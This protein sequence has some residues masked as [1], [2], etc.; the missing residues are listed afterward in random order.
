MNLKYLSKN[1]LEE[2][3]LLNKKTKLESSKE[4]NEDINP[5]LLNLEQKYKDENLIPNKNTNI[6]NKK[7]N[8]NIKDDN[9]I[10]KSPKEQ[11]NENKIVL[12]DADNDKIKETLKSLDE[13]IYTKNIKEDFLCNVCYEIASKNP[14]K[15]YSQSKCNHILC[16]LCWSKTLYEKLECPLCRNKVRVKTLNRLEYV[17]Q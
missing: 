6:I 11:I 12:N 13:N 8:Q 7:E 5:N 9:K 3:S 17:P 1:N 15:K 10:I 2:N 4:N 14:Q 16:N